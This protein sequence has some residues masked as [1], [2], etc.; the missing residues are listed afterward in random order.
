MIGFDDMPTSFRVEATADD[1]KGRA[2]DFFMT[3][4][5]GNDIILDSFAADNVS[6]ADGNRIVNGILVSRLRISREAA[7]RMRDLLNAE[8]AGMVTHNDR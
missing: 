5:I 4:S 6:I 1:R 8:L 3:S 7:E 2:A